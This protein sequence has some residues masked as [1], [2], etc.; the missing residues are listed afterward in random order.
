MATTDQKPLLY[1]NTSEGLAERTGNTMNVAQGKMATTAT[2][3]ADW[4]L[5]QEQEAW[6]L[7]KKQAEQSS[8]LAAQFLTQWTTGLGDMKSMFGEAFKTL[9]SLSGQISG[10]SGG[11]MNPLYDI[12][13]Q[14]KGEYEA[15]RSDMAPVEQEFLQMSREEGAG[16]K[17]A[18]GAITEGLKADYSGTTGR[19]AADV[20]TQSAAGLEAESRRL[21]SMGVDP[22]SGAF[23]ALSKKGALDTARN[24]AIAVNVARRGEKERVTNL[25]LQAAQVLDPTKSANTAVAIRKGGTDIL[26]QQASVAGKA[27]DLDIA[28]IGAIGNIAQTAGQLATGYASAVNQPMGEMAGY[29][30]GRAGA[31]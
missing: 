25:G 31:I 18:V 20:R 3:A 13:N 19:A 2:K 16:K 4:Q 29:M 26:G 24:T 14:I 28:K 17:A 9:T 27:G 1:W 6:D 7:K 22:S 23:G 30:L 10:G 8:G 11:A 21:M 12:A 5:S 15:Y